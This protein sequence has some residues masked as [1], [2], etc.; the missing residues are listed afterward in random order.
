LCKISAKTDMVLYNFHFSFFLMLDRSQ[1]MQACITACQWPDT[2]RNRCSVLSTGPCRV[3]LSL[4]LHKMLDRWVKVYLI[5]ATNHELVSI[6]LWSLR[7]YILWEPHSHHDKGSSLNPFQGHGWKKRSTVGIC[8][9][10]DTLERP[11]R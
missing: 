1:Y 4:L 9:H 2:L 3:L 10:P 8:W 6:A 7:A 5:F 11:T